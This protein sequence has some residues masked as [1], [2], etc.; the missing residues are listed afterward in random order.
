MFI[1]GVVLLAYG[2]RFRIGNSSDQDFQLTPVPAKRRGAFLALPEG[3]TNLLP[4]SFLHAAL[5][6]FPETTGAKAM[7]QR[8]ARPD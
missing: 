3:W 1:T 4:M 5:I 7:G 2:V 6:H 8:K